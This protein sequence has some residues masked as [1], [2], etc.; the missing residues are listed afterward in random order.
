MSGEF[1]KPGRPA[2]DGRFR[3]ASP[4]RAR[5]RHRATVLAMNRDGASS[6]LAK[7][8][9]RWSRDHAGGEQL[10][11]DLPYVVAESPSV[12]HVGSLP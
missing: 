11:T 1:R 2:R 12:E 9:S 7:R 5:A 10:G 4:G 8:V 3:W 6:A